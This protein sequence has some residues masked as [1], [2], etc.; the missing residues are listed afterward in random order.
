MVNQIDSLGIRVFQ[1]AT[2]LD[3]RRFFAALR[4]TF[5]V[6]LNEVKGLLCAINEKIVLGIEIMCMVLK[7]YPL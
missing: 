3:K 2:F 1:L 4:M 5:Y 7:S 6:T